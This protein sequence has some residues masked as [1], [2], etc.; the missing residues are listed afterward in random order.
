MREFL[1]II[2]QSESVNLEVTNYPSISL[3]LLFSA[4]GID[5]EYYYFDN[6]PT[7]NQS[8]VDKAIKHWVQLFI[9]Y[10][11]I[12]AKGEWNPIADSLKTQ[13]AMKCDLSELRWIT[14]HYKELEQQF[15]IRD[16]IERKLIHR[17]KYTLK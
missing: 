17:L 5:P 6:N 7:I 15:R 8:N 13:E 11:W 2:S 10:E 9:R 1:H 14:A 3:D 4:L 16:R 12:R